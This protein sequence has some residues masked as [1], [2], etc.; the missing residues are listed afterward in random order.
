MSSLKEQVGRTDTIKADYEKLL[1]EVCEKPELR[2]VR[3][4]VSIDDCNQAEK[5]KA[6]LVTE[7]V[8][9]IDSVVQQLG[10]KTVSRVR[11]GLE[12]AY[13]TVRVPRPVA[14]TGFS[15]VAATS[16][17]WKGEARGDGKESEPV[18]DQSMK[19]R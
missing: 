3:L 11:Q 10:Y 15:G 14:L 16:I 9:A 13:S 1:A 8:N 7:S 4:N 5:L 2:M 17:G 19:T 18:E 12:M 6:A